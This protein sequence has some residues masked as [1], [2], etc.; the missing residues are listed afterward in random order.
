MRL[1][2]FLVLESLLS[3]VTLT[4][5][6]VWLLW[7]TAVSQQQSLSFTALSPLFC[8][9]LLHLQ[10]M[11]P[12]PA[13]DSLMKTLPSLNPAA[14][15]AVVWPTLW[16]MNISG[17][18]PNLFNLPRAGKENLGNMINTRTLFFDRALTQ[19]IETVE[20]VVV[21]GAGFDTRLLKFCYG[22][23]LS[24]FEVDRPE[25]Q[26]VKQQALKESGQPTDGIHFVPV[27]FNEEN[28]I[29]RLKAAGFL[30]GKK[31][32]FLWEGVTY[33]LT[34]AIVV[35][36]LRAMGEVCSVGS[37]IACDFFPLHLLKGQAPE[38]QAFWWMPLATNVLDWIGEPFRFGV[39]TQTGNREAIA[40]LLSHSAFQLRELQMMGT[41]KPSSIE[42]LSRSS[43]RQGSGFCGLVIAEIMGTET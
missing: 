33:Y 20:Q 41:G 4:G 9:W 23:K 6:F 10:G 36:S 37:A 32:F 21:L 26:R 7:G 11:R 18:T 40:Q 43:S 14:N 31:T 3:P 35:E 30:P 24:L 38:G 25:M 22:K 34:E 27:N 1:F 8:R 17:Y 42:P 29:E 19:Y 15:W 2:T 13:A 28:W 12:D 16:A 5:C 39:D